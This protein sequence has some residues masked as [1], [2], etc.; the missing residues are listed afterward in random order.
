MTT[1]SRVAKSLLCWLILS[2]LVVVILFPYAVM[3]FTAIKPREEIL[4]YPP[5][6]LPSRVDL[7]NFVEMWDATGFGPALVNSL[8]VS[9]AAT[10]L[11]LAVAIPAAYALSRFRFAGRGLY[12]QFLLVTQMLSPIVLVIGIFRLMA[13]L[14]LVDHLN[15][16]VLTYGAFTVAFAVWMLQSYFATIP[17]ELEEAAWIDGCS[18]LQA[19]TRI[20]VPLAVPAVTVTAILTF[21][22]SWNEFVLA[23]TLLRSDAQFTLPL[24]VFSLVGGRY[25]VEWDH[26]MAATFLA[27]VPVAIVFAW[28]QRYLVQ[29]LALGAVK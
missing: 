15:A 5:R 19:L 14:G 24:K 9:F 17:V 12:R 29:G 4:A 27:T 7:A 6:W 25:S 11:C 26:V 10:L 16:L 28:L 23:L 1:R 21:I 13:W 3:V 18:R 2:P 22:F 20:F 8:Y